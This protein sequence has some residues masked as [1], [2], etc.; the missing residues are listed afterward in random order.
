[1]ALVNKSSLVMRSSM[2]DID[3]AT[4]HAHVAA[5]TWITIPH[6]ERSENKCVI[7][8]AV[9][10]LQTPIHGHENGQLV[11]HEP[12]DA[13]PITF[14]AKKTGVNRRCRPNG[15]TDGASDLRYVTSESG[16]HAEMTVHLHIMR[17]REPI[18]FRKP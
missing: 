15:T 3:G 4:V 7:S 12:R 17:P 16:V 5:M 6:V 18:P 14:H 11:L 1:M 10:A 8:I 13:R 2:D 9:E